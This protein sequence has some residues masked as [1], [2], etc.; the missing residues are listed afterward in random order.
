MNWKW[1]SRQKSPESRGKP[2]RQLQTKS[3]D[4]FGPQGWPHWAS[5]YVIFNKL[6]LTFNHAFV[7]NQC[8]LAPICLQTFKVYLTPVSRV[9]SHCSYVWNVALIRL[10]CC[11]FL[12]ALACI[13]QFKYLFCFHCRFFVIWSILFKQRQ[14]FLH[15]MLVMSF[16][17]G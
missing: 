11:V 14:V 4:M 16:Q 15:W 10:K 17:Y 1:Q 9:H 7:L 5:F 3:P 2:A 13:F 12:C 8:Q 6:I